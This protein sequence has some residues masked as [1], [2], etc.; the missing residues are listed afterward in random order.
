MDKRGIFVVG[1][2]GLRFPRL[3][4]STIILL[5]AVTGPTAAQELTQSR[6]AREPTAGELLAVFPVDAMRSRQDGTAVLRCSVAR[7]A[8]LPKDCAVIGETPAGAGFGA[9]ALAVSD[10]YRLA[11]DF[12]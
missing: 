11:D 5:L 7:N 4:T 1:M 9:A 8:P 6:W 2:S 12:L 3:P 10:R